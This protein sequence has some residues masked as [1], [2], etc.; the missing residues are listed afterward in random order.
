MFYLTLFFLLFTLSVVQYLKIA[1]SSI[2][3]SSSLRPHNTLTPLSTSEASEHRRA[4]IE[5]ALQTIIP[6][7]LKHNISSWLYGGTLLGYHRNGR[8]ILGDTDGDVV[9]D[10][11]DM[12]KLYSVR[13]TVSSSS[14][15][16]HNG[17]HSHHRLS[18]HLTFARFI[19]EDEAY[20]D[21]YFSIIQNDVLRLLHRDDRC[22]KHPASLIYPLKQS[23][24]LGMKVWVPHNVPGLLAFLYGSGWTTPCQRGDCWVRKCIVDPT[25]G[26]VLVRKKGISTNS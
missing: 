21:I 25:G 2:M 7:L 4:N 13:K 17:L 18:F 3:S 22:V 23:T 11:Q 26:L 9:V 14:R 24:F 6:L 20:V 19:V 12:Y 5:R 8:V 1:D 16:R 10:A 15:S